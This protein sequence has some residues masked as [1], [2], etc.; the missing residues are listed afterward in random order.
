[1]TATNTSKGYSLALTSAVILSTTAIFIR[2]LTEAY[3]MPAMVLAF[4]RAG[5]AAATLVLALAVIK[6][7]LLKVDRR[8]LGYLF[9]YGLVLAGFNATWTFAVALTGASIATVLVNASAAFTAVL[10]WRFLGERLSWGKSL[11]VLV[12]IAGCM[13]VAKV[14]DPE[15]WDINALGILTGVASAVFYALYSLMGR[16]AAQRGLSPWTVV[17]YT[18]SFSCAALFALNAALG[19]MLPDLGSGPGGY[20]MLGDSL[21]GWF[22][23]IALAAGPTVVGFGMYN[24]S[25]RHLPSSVANLIMTSE[26]VFTALIAYRLFGEQLDAAQ[27]I[28]SA[29]VLGGVVLLRALEWRD[30]PR[31]VPLSSG[32]ERFSKQRVSPV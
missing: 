3:H 13:V 9:V 25:M 10:A 4:W 6:P 19:S 15:A 7:S 16:R 28:G 12:S 23:L 21:A 5:L 29:M 8:D 30:T 32:G 18:F 31:T 14:S 1:M 22:W 26:P 2:H 27:L 20:F 17:A 11:V 24:A